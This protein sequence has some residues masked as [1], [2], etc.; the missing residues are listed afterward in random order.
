FT[1]MSKLLVTRGAVL[2]Y[3]P[4]EGK[5]R[6]AT[7]RGVRGMKVGDLV[8]VAVQQSGKPL[9][10]DQVPSELRA[11]DLKLVL[12]VASGHRDIGL[13]ALGAKATNQAFDLRELQFMQSLVNMTSAAV[14]NSLVVAELTQA[15]RDLD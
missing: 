2:L 15:N 5:H 6:V 8:D 1:A 4:L 11:H 10:D 12:P 9:L 14:H 7:A 13:I 3:E